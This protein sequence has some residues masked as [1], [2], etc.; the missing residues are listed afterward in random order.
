M[1]YG[2]RLVGGSFLI[3]AVGGTVWNSFGL[4]LVALEHEFGWSRGEISMAFSLYALMGAVTSPVIGWLLDRVDSRWVLTA[5][6]LLMVAGLSSTALVQTVPGYYLAFGGLAGLGFHS[7]S[8]VAQFIILANWFRIRQGT[9]LAVAEAGSGLAVFLGLP[10][11]QLI[12]SGAGW[13]FTYLVLALSVLVIVLPLNLLLMRF[14][15]R[16]LGLQADGGTA[17]AD[18][19]AANHALVPSETRLQLQGR[20]LWLAVAFIIGPLAYQALLTQQVILLVDTGLSELFAASIA[21]IG[22]LAVMT[23]R[24]LSGWLAD[25]YGEPLVLVFTT[26]S[27]VGSILCLFAIIAGRGSLPVLYAYPVLLGFGFG[28][29]TPLFASAARR[30][31][32]GDRFGT[33]YGFLRVG[34]GLG[35]AA[36]AVLAGTL[37]DRTGSYHLVLI[38]ALVCALGSCIT[39]W[40]AA[41]HTHDDGKTTG[42]IAT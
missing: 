27:A 13:R 21:A 8:S 37:Y 42:G 6:A 41:P 26:L 36:G 23:A 19:A 10:L 29:N 5:S 16:E 20:L 12:L 14:H 30:L 2:W 38:M 24:L 1:F 18:M 7:L 28:A 3:L 40:A 9:A 35:G 34:T 11:V 32:P 25:R 33:F 22:G 39:L 17:T 4:F 31:W 15:P